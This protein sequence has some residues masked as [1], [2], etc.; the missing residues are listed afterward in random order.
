MKACE[1]LYGIPGNQDL[2]SDLLLLPCSPTT[3][4]R[5]ADLASRR[6]PRR[7]HHR[8][9]GGIRL[10]ASAERSRLLHH[11][12]DSRAAGL[13]LVKRLRRQRTLVRPQFIFF[14][15][16]NTRHSLRRVGSGRCAEDLVR[17]DI[18]VKMPGCAQVLG[19]PGQIDLL[20]FPRPKQQHQQLHPDPDKWLLHPAV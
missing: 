19:R 14:L 12:H 11:P 4:L 18:F 2:P 16:Q 20:Q 10:R 3:L 1:W 17:S 9:P 7:R 5:S 8:R 15:V 6:G 13:H